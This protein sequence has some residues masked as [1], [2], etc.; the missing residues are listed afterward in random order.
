GEVDLASDRGN[1]NLESGSS[2]NVRGFGGAAG[3]AAGGDAGAIVVSAGILNA[4]NT[5]SGI[6]IGGG[7]LLG[8]AAPG[9]RGGSFTL[10]TGSLGDATGLSAALNAGGFSEARNLRV[11][12]G[13]VVIGGISTAH[14]F[15]V[16]ADAGSIE[17]HGTV[18]ASGTR[19]GTILLAAG[20]NVTL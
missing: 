10:N 8:T 3:V 20:G 1:V 14:S 19:G 7:Q 9:N 11:R 17:V 6:F 13:N 2:I 15:T 18:D 12:T 16:S 4:S 5:G